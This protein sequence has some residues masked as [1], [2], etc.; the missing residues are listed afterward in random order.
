MVG[1]FS[2]ETLYSV[3]RS[4][5]ILQNFRLYGVK[6]AIFS[7]INYGAESIPKLT[8]QSQ[9]IYTKHNKYIMF[10][11]YINW[12][13]SITLNLFKRI[14]IFPSQASYCVWSAGLQ[15][16]NKHFIPCIMTSILKLPFIHNIYYAYVS[17]LH[18]ICYKNIS[19]ADLFKKTHII[20]VITDIL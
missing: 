15:N 2:V 9:N 3:L 13:L 11:V 8:R 7:F 19:Y 1:H 4:G 14:N 16:V 5:Y 18:I 12:N 20:I 17:S 6:S 10:T